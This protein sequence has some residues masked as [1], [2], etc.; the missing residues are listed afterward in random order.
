MG[1][2]GFGRKKKNNNSGSEIEKDAN[3]VKNKKA[4][5]SIKKTESDKIK[6]P[7]IFEDNEK[8]SKIMSNIRFDGNFSDLGIEIG[9][10]LGEVINPQVV[11]ENRVK[12][13]LGL[14]NY[15]TKDLIF[16]ASE[17]SNGI[18]GKQYKQDCAGYMK[19]LNCR[20]ISDI[21]KESEIARLYCLDLYCKDYIEFWQ[22]MQIYA[23][24]GNNTD[25]VNLKY[26]V[27][28]DRLEQT[29][30]AVDV[31]RESISSNLKRV[32][33]ESYNMK[34][35]NEERVR[36]QLQRFVNL[37]S[38]DYE[39]PDDTWV[40]IYKYLNG[41]V[42]S[43]MKLKLDSKGI[44]LGYGFELE[45]M[46]IGAPV[47]VEDKS[48][49]VPV[50]VGESRTS[51]QEEMSQTSYFSEE[52]KIQGIG[53]TVDIGDVEDTHV[54]SEEPIA[55][56]ILAFDD[57][58]KNLEKDDNTSQFK[59]NKISGEDLIGK[60]PLIC[61]KMSDMMTS[62]FKGDAFNSVLRQIYNL[63]TALNSSKGIDSCNIQLCSSYNHMSLKQDDLDDL[64]ETLNSHDIDLVD[65][66]FTNVLNVIH[67]VV[68]SNVN[69]PIFIIYDRI[70]DKTASIIKMRE[71]HSIFE[72]NKVVFVQLDTDVPDNFESLQAKE[73]SLFVNCSFILATHE[74]ISNPLT[75]ANEL[76]NAL[77]S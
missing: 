49:D 17:S 55:E 51:T 32:I 71:M 7:I 22:V 77:F 24:L 13:F 50:V 40:S 56:E 39:I 52:T 11:S 21:V 1:F 69:V 44:Q 48:V 19:Q 72:N 18:T 66:H 16:K 15:K 36:Y 62:Y 60:P 2:F 34:L 74:L 47:S 68:S 70:I 42:T 46:D 58:K 64:I 10:S 59:F 20:F 53:E 14:R 45:R 75:L 65:F 4:G 57:Y 29:L 76:R 3:S 61:V 41:K 6:A 8:F 31:S 33:I 12:L 37:V 38:V 25:E 73:K 67:E 28:M 35:S 27:M 23:L 30:F 63:N 26:L 43:G 54:P 9:E 5:K